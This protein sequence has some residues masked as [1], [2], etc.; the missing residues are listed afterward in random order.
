[1]MA[2]LLVTLA[3]IKTVVPSCTDGRF[4]LHC[5][6]LESEEESQYHISMMKQG[7]LLILLF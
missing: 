2:R 5:P 3:E 1:M 4:I 7:K 6:I